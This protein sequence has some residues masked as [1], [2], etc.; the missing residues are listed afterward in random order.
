MSCKNKAA[1]CAAAIASDG[2]PVAGTMA[3]AQVL[4]DNGY[5]RGLVNLARFREWL[6]GPKKKELSQAEAGEALTGLARSAERSRWNPG[7]GG[8]PT[9]MRP[10]ERAGLGR[11]P[12]GE[13]CGV[14]EIGF[15]ST[16][17]SSQVTA[18]ANGPGQDVLAGQNAPAPPLT[19]P[20]YQPISS[21]GQLP[22]QIT[23]RVTGM[24][25][26]GRTPEVG[27][28][29]GKPT[30]PVLPG[31]GSTR[32]KYL[33]RGDNFHRAGSQVQQIVTTPGSIA[34]DY[35][36]PDAGVWAAPPD[37]KEIPGFNAPPGFWTIH[38]R[39]LLVAHEGVQA[40][41]YPTYIPGEVSR[42]INPRQGV[43]LSATGVACR[44]RDGYLAAR[45]AQPAPQWPM[46]EP[47]SISASRL[48]KAPIKIHTTSG[49]Q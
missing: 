28:C 44:A 30:D 2:T 17:T 6:D 48:A 32:Y 37:A 39:L 49:F 24:R 4:K 26:D 22:G 45:Q 33:R 20:L 1:T 12:A 21:S 43:T 41:L 34:T 29:R 18:L 15:G 35:H 16:Y 13:F 11:M 10:A 19:E 27:F 7:P 40:I 5:Y 25:E 42:P 23:G 47:A 8:I 46:M 36:G 31:K 3:A 14:W 38:Y 9:P